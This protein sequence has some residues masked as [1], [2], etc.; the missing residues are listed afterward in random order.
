[1]DLNELIFMHPNIIGKMVLVKC[2][3]R[4]NKFNDLNI[5]AQTADKMNQFYKS[6]VLNVV[7]F[8]HDKPDQDGFI[9]GTI[10]IT[11]P[12]TERNFNLFID[13]LTLNLKNAKSMIIDQNLVILTEEGK[14]IVQEKIILEI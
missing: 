5:C 1:M 10:S 7:S 14:H 3:V 8:D 11:I 9:K 2:T 4:I 6:D 13:M 12:L